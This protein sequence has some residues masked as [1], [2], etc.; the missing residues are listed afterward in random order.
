M[1]M[2]LKIP[3]AAVLIGFGTLGV[4]KLNDQYAQKIHD[5]FIGT[6]AHLDVD[7]EIKELRRRGY[8][9]TSQMEEEE[10]REYCSSIDMDLDVIPVYPSNPDSS[11]TF[12]APRLMAKC[13]DPELNPNYD[14][15]E[16]WAN[17][18]LDRIKFQRK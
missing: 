12:T 7:S 4:V 14:V 1:R 17:S 8:T 9:E 15:D 2:R 18:V 3:I 5:H 6:T 16:D 13:I 11:N 10:R